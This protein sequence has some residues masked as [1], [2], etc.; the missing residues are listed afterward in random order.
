MLSLMPGL[1]LV[2]NS[3]FKNRKYIYK[4]IVCEK[5][6]YTGCGGSQ[7][8]FATEDLCELRCDNDN[9]DSFESVEN[10]REYPLRKFQYFVLGK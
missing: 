1:L 4:N 10:F 8:L 7:N 9:F 2:S 3:L 6:F 5:I